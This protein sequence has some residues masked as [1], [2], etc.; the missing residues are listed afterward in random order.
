[1]IQTK[2][3]LLES[4]ECLKYAGMNG[5]IMG[6]LQWGAQGFFLYCKYVIINESKKTT[7]IKD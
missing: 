4:C 3:I 7:N 6:C 1:M 2:I 5:V